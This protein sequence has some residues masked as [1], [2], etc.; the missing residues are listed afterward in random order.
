MVEILGFIPIFKAASLSISLGDWW[1]AGDSWY[2]DER[3]CCPDVSRREETLQAQ[4]CTTANRYHL[5]PKLCL[6]VYITHS[7][8]PLTRSYEH[9]Y[10]FEYVFCSLAMLGKGQLQRGSRIMCWFLYIFLPSWQPFL[11]TI[12]DPDPLL[13]FQY[14]LFDEGRTWS[15][16]ISIS[17]IF[18]M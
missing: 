17:L 2:R 9:I 12:T 3:Q 6:S 18:Q 11:T 4:A 8:Q 5:S 14:K 13:P 1:V 10:I 15:I 7:L 16:V